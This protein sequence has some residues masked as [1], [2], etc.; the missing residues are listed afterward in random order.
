MQLLEA[1]NATGSTSLIYQ[2]TWNDIPENAYLELELYQETNP[3]SNEFDQLIRTY[4][5][6]SDLGPDGRG[7]QETNQVDIDAGIL[8]NPTIA[9]LKIYDSERNLHEEHLHGFGNVVVS[10]EVSEPTGQ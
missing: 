8:A 3:G 9:R 1:T 4:E 5:D 7:S 6:L 2:A 10:N